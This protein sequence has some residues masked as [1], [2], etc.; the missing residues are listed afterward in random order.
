MA[1]AIP[2]STLQN[3]SVTFNT[4]GTYSV[5]LT[6]TDRLGAV[7][8]D[9]PVRI[10]TVRE[11]LPTGCRDNDR[12]G[13]SPDGG[14]CG[15]VDCN[16]NNPAVNPGAVERC[17]DGIDNDCNGQTD[18]ADKACNG[19]DCVAALLPAA[20]VAITRA[21]WDAEDRKLTVRGQN[22]PA[23]SAADLFDAVT[24]A[25][26]SNTV[27]KGS[28]AWEFEVERLATAPCR[29]RVEIAGQR[30]EAA[31][32]GTPASCGTGTGTPIPNAA[33]DGRIATPANGARVRLGR[34][35]AFSATGSDP[36]ANLPLTYLWDFG[37]G[38]TS[39][40]QNPSVTFRA[41]G[42]VVVRLTVRDAKGLADPTPAQITIQVVE[43]DDLNFNPLKDQ[44]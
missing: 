9:P 37:S 28:G 40:L 36:D 15:P 44:A 29:V 10:V 25:L 16:D 43:G 23:G 19:R 27:V 7:V 4:V 33:P 30:A 38:V 12:D 18:S 1:V 42:S 34:S 17:G 35:V 2:D 24:G 14:P 22:A 20:P 3:P 32:S 41:K 31:V 8:L 13:F 26:L 39:S 11:P 21:R 6:V 5:T